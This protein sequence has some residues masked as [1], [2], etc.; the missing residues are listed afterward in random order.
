MQKQF[1]SHPFK[2]SIKNIYFSQNFMII[3]KLHNHNNN[4]IV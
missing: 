4:K 1:Y 3:V 2:M